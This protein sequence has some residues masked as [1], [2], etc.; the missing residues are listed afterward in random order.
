MVLALGL[1]VLAFGQDV[2]QPRVVASWPAGPME[3]RV[4][5]DAPWDES[6]G[7]ALV[8]K[9]VRFVTD[10]KFE[11]ELAIAA[12]HLRDEGRTLVLATDPHSVNASFFLPNPLA[13]SALQ[14]TPYD[15]SGVEATW[16]EREDDDSP[17]I[18]TW[19]PSLESAAFQALADRSIEH[20]RFR[21][22]L[23]KQGRLI[24]KSRVALPK[25]KRTLRLESNVAMSV[26][27]N[28]DEKE[29]K[30]VLFEFEATEVPEDL[31][32]RL[33]TGATMPSL[34]MTVGA[35]APS[36]LPKILL[37]PWSPDPPVVGGT[38]FEAPY[39]L[40]GGDA[41]RGEIVFFSEDSKC[42]ICHKI[43][44]KGGD[45]GPDLTRPRQRDL[46]SLFRAIAAPSD[47]IRP[48]YVP[49]TIATNDGIVAVGTVRAEGADSLRVLDAEG[50]STIFKRADVQLF[51]A[52][53]TSIMPVGL[54]GALGEDRMRDLLA[55]L[56]TQRPQP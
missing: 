42:S 8:G 46:P 12:A 6:K 34:R 44:G 33:S 14:V 55:F 52:G 28:N 35:D 40:V 23:M 53:S 32:V 3:T 1:L 30:S 11:G 20:G 47:E 50:K 10:W 29:G 56:L 2:P 5:F 9:A 16:R 26:E 18:V 22:A 4:A 38:P 45:V 27:L 43:G 39:D 13:H 49:Y 54:A 21:A 7:Q 24:L 15:L 51:K 41:K 25:G 36:K 37:V 48:D 31:T 19:W 17:S